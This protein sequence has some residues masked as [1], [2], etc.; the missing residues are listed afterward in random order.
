MTIQETIKVLKNLYAYYDDDLDT[1]VE[2][3]TVAIKTLKKVK[4]GKL[5]ELPCKVGDKVYQITN[6]G[7]ISTYLISSIVIDNAINVD[8]FF[9]W[10]IIDGFANNLL[11]FRASEIGET[12]FLTR[13]EA[14]KELEE[15]KNE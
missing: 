11:G 7:T 14:E 9:K 4:S 15:M 1:T 8:I 12:V 5:I 2:A 10:L 3:L 13:K 6:R